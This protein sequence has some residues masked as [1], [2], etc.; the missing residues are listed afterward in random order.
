[1][2]VLI[3]ASRGEQPRLS[4]GNLAIMCHEDGS[5]AVI[6]QGERQLATVRRRNPTRASA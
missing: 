1:M 5:Y 3:A 2:S 4:G 6:E